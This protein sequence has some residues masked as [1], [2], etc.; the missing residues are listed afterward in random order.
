[1]FT[2]DLDGTKSLKNVSLDVIKVFNTKAK[3]NQVVFDS[4]FKSFLLW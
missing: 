4:I 1:M 2:F 3:P